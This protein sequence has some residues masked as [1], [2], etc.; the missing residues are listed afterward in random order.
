M[1]EALA[2]LYS[3]GGRLPWQVR[4]NPF[5]APGAVGSGPQKAPQR[6]PGGKAVAP[7]RRRR[8]PASSSGGAACRSSRSEAP[9]TSLRKIS[10]YDVRT[11]Q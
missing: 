8:R 3:V 5:I 2:P 9:S 6:V 4:W 10:Q 11:S 7:S 1:A